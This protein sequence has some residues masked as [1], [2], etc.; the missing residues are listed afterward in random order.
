MTQYASIDKK[1]KIKN[2]NTMAISFCNETIDAEKTPWSSAFCILWRLKPH[3]LA[4]TYKGKMSDLMAI[5][6]DFLCII[7]K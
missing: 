6:G 4:L 3:I 1:I 7:K 2:I 5:S